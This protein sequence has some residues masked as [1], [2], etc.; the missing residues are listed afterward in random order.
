MKADI[1][2]VEHLAHLMKHGCH[3]LSVVLSRRRQ[4]VTTFPHSLNFQLQN[5]TFKGS[6]FMAGRWFVLWKYSR[7]QDYHLRLEENNS[8]SF[9]QYNIFPQIEPYRVVKL[10]VSALHE[11]YYELS[12]KRT[13]CLL[14]SLMA[15]LMVERKLPIEDVSSETVCLSNFSEFPS[16]F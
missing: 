8:M 12:V 1:V 11:I 15:D 10:E 5:R 16:R 14:Y 4:L 6:Q 9:P 7:T 2:L 3:F 13:V